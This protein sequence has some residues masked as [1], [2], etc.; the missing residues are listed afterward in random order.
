MSLGLSLL[1]SRPV[2]SLKASKSSPPREARLARM[3]LSLS[4]K[5]AKEW[6]IDGISANVR[7]VMAQRRGSMAMMK[8]VLRDG[9]L[10]G[11]LGS[12]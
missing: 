4:A 9:P 2:V 5:D 7:P 8:R 12:P 1:I 11:L 10:E 3:M 6:G